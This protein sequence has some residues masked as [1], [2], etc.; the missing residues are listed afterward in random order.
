MMLLFLVPFQVFAVSN[1]RLNGGASYTI[2]SIPD[3]V[4][5]TCDLAQTGN[6]LEVEIY[7]DVDG[8]NSVGSDDFLMQFLVLTDGIG[9]IRDSG[10]PDEDISG[11]ETGADKKIQTTIVYE[12]GDVGLLQG[13]FIVR[14]KDEDGSTASGLLKLDVQAQP[15]LIQGKV[16]EQGTATPIQGVLVFAEGGDEDSVVGI[17]D[18]N[19]DY[20]LSVTPGTWGVMAIDYY[21][22]MYQPSDSVSVTVGTGE[23]KT[24]NIQMKKYTTF[25]DGTIKKE[26]GTP[27]PALMVF[28]GNISGEDA[29][30]DYSD[31]NGYYKIGVSPGQV[32]VMVSSLF[33]PDTWPEG[34]FVEQGTD[35]VQVNE[36]QTVTVNFILKPLSTFIEGTCTESGMGLAG[37]EISAMS[38]DFTTFQVSQTT[39][40]TGQDGKYKLGVLPGMVTFLN[41]NKEGYE[42]I[43]PAGG[44][45]FSIQI[46]EGQTISGKDFVLK[47]ATGGGSMSIAGTVTHA[48]NS[49]AANVY[50]VAINDMEENREG[51]R[52]LYTDGSGHYKF[53]GLFSGLWKVGVFKAG[54]ESDPPMRK[55]DLWPGFEITDADFKLGEGTGIVALNDA[56][57]PQG[58]FLEQNYP[59]PFRPGAGTSLTNLQFYLD[60]SATT[61]ISIFNVTGQLVKR[62]SG[63]ILQ[64]GKHG[65]SWDGRDETGEIVPTGVYF[66]HV[67]AGDQSLTKR[68]LLIR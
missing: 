20:Q 59:N 12:K 21:Q 52:I 11:D 53:D 45:Y 42:V 14:V 23:T 27:V 68:L 1:F 10:N 15:P 29:F 17:T 63:G 38:I 35:T 34:Y 30:F 6:E 31:N 25:V 36:G 40:V 9:W 5:F 56:I 33:N 65:Y 66:Y 18:E 60:R 49:P 22:G 28:A 41:A 46:N 54:Y 47:K 43:D 61:E 32:A 7:L 64:A 26:D 57:A 48:D 51:F 58:F 16:T 50:V 8:N 37:V 19:G 39:T 4:V 62:I 55:E 3:Q 24:Q 2:T 44:G 13:Q 67:T